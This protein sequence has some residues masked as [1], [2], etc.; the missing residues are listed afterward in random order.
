MHGT[1]HSFDLRLFINIHFGSKNELYSCAR[2]T[3]FYSRQYDDLSSLLFQNN[4]TENETTTHQP[5]IIGCR[6]SYCCTLSRLPILSMQCSWTRNFQ[7][8]IASNSA[9]TLFYFKRYFVIENLEFSL[10]PFFLL[11]LSFEVSN[12]VFAQQNTTCRVK[13]LTQLQCTQLSLSAI[14]NNCQKD[15]IIDFQYVS[16]TTKCDLTEEDTYPSS[17]RLTKE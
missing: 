7:Q 5:P 13:F 11:K 12:I 8:H 6:L 9:K 4:N 10:L 2:V 1:D 16:L 17:C 14:T 3:N 15:T